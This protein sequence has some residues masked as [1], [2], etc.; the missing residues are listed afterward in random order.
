[1]RTNRLMHRRDRRV[2]RLA[3]AVS[4]A[5][6]AP[7]RSPRP[8]LRTEGRVANDPGST[9]YR[10]RILDV[11]PDIRRPRDP[12]HQKPAP[13]SSSST[14]LAREVIVRG[15]EGE[16]YL[17]IDDDGVFREP[18]VACHPEPLPVGRRRRSRRKR[19]PRTHRTGNA[20]TRPSARWHDH[21]TWMG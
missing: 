1:M 12:R 18:A 21:R 2:R 8:P 13:D 7:S 17:R 14:A 5:L 10:T 15:A 19:T 20:S 3:V 9:N 4:V 6:A 11:D 16:P